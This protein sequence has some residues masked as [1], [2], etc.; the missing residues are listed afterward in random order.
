MAASTLARMAAFTSAGS[1]ANT[2][3]MGPASD[4]VT[5]HQSSTDEKWTGLGT[6]RTAASVSP[7]PTNRSPSAPG[8][9]S[10]N[11]PGMPGGGT[12]MRVT[13]VTASN[14]RPNHGL[15]SRGP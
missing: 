11:G 1:D 12:G 14:S 5:D 4:G 15:S 13:A 7:A 2:R 9:S 8:A 6:S 3:A 10:E